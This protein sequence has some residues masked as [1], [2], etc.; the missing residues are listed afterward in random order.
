V[1]ISLL[2]FHVFPSLEHSGRAV[3]RLQRGQTFSSPIF[4]RMHILRLFIFLIIR[5]PFVSRTSAITSKPEQIALLIQIQA[6]QSAVKPAAQSFL[7]LTEKAE[8]MQNPHIAI[9]FASAGYYSTYLYP[10]NSFFLYLLNSLTSIFLQSTS[11]IT[12][13]P[14]PK[15]SIACSKSCFTSPGKPIRYIADI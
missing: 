13:M 14:A 8:L 9:P 1:I 15:I 10:P 2:V 6:S 5:T 7:V 3:K 4:I 12:L 11:L